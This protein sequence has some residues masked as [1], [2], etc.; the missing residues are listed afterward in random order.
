MPAK[1]E[2]YFLATP[3]NPKP[4]IS[5][6]LP[7]HEVCAYHAENTFNAS[8]IYA[9]VSTSISRTGAWKTLQST[10]G[11][12]LIAHRKGIRPHTPW[13]DVLSITS[14]LTAHKP[15][16]IITLG[17]GSVT[18]AVKLARLAAAN[19]VS[20][21]DDLEVLNEKAG[22][23]DPIKQPDED[24][25]GVRLASI[26]VINVPTTLSGGEFTHVS[27]AT[28]LRNNH[29]AIFPHTS[30]LADIVVLDP[31]LSISTPA[32]IWLS[33]GMRAV[34]HCVE[35][36]YGTGPGA[37]EEI[38][39][40]LLD[41]LKMLLPNLLRTKKDWENEEARLQEFLAVSACPKAVRCGIGSSHGIGHQLGPLGVGH[42]ETSCVMLPY[43]L[44]WN[45]EHGDDSVKE[46]ER[47]AF[48]VFWADEVVAEVLR[49]K[50]L[51]KETTDPGD[52]V[53][54]FVEELGMPRSL[55]DVGVGREHFDKLA[56]SAMKD[57]CTKANPVEM[58]KERVLEILEMASGD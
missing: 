38:R 12:K 11:S 45:W 29:K 50:G 54:A 44:K 41:S 10:L 35:G 36:L 49:R 34:D 43:V 56:E 8:R 7:F 3:P 55:K 47:M 52:V 32:K 1:G 28:D 16:L 33:T 13:D 9:V 4:Y 30:Q 31:A 40:E 19:G 15:D 46:R 18:D 37:T 21:T 39:G 14:D 23:V 2:T 42:G 57:W 22:K 6:G 51:T 5:H 17:A 25:P 48:D 20:S 26:P 24:A 53:G 58:S 27:G